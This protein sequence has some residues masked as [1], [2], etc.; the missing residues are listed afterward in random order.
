ME[1]WKTTIESDR[2]E[3]S[4]EGRIRSKRFM[5]PLSSNKKNNS[6][7]NVWSHRIGTNKFKNNFIHRTVYKA[8][9]GDIPY[10]MCINHIDFNKNNNSIENLELT[11]VFENLNH[12]RINGRFNSANEMHSE[13]M[14]LENQRRN[15]K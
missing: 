12:S 2:Y 5:T 15:K 3:V 4:N 10:G 8:F 14:K 11:T 1:I 7:Y 6:G 13:F 9:V